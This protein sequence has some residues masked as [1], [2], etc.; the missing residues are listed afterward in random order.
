MGKK[1]AAGGRFGDYQGQETTFY[2][3]LDGKSKITP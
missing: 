2:T 3:L 1:G